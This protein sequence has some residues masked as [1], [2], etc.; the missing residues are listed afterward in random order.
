MKLKY[1]ELH[2]LKSY[3]VNEQFL[4]KEEF[5]TRFN[6]YPWLEMLNLVNS[7]PDNQIHYSP[8]LN[9]EDDEGKGISVSI[10]GEIDSHEYYISYK[11]PTI[12]KGTKWLGF[13]SYEY[14]DENF[15]SLIPQQTKQDAMD[16]FIYFYDRNFEALEKRW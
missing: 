16:A 15:A 13:V 2:P 7:A 5:I 6:E 3:A 1:S 14:L 4:T 11:R 12:R 8:S 10:V 9:L